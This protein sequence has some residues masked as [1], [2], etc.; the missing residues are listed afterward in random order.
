MRLVSVTAAGAPHGERR[1]CDFLAH[2]GVNHLVGCGFGY[3]GLPSLHGLDHGLG[4]NLDLHHAYGQVAQPVSDQ[5][6]LRRA[7]GGEPGHHL[8]E[9]PAHS[10]RRKL[11]VAFI[12]EGFRDDLP[13]T[14]GRPHALIGGHLDV[15]EFNGVELVAVE[16]GQRFHAHSWRSQIDHQD[17]QPPGAPVGLARATQQP[18]EI[19][20]L[21]VGLPALVAIDHVGVPA[22]LRA[23]AHR[24]EVRAGLGARSSPG[25]NAACRREWEAAS[26]L[27]ARAFR[28]AAGCARRFPRPT[29]CGR[30]ARRPPRPTARIHRGCP[31]RAPRS[32]WATR[33]PASRADPSPRKNGVPR[34][35]LRPG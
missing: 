2:H 32:A 17:R 26:A 28:V 16:R 1:L 4:M 33:A 25:R 27:V 21:R 13:G 10:T 15:G 20:V 14:I 7:F 29:G 34:A 19:H 3:R 30:R 6:T 22:P 8:F 35:T 23:T 18:E 9:V 12:R 5:G 11:D 24:R 31:F